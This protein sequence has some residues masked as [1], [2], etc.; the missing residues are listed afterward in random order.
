MAVH[1]LA[2]AGLADLGDEARLII[3]GDEVIEVVV[4]LQNHAAAAPAVAAAGP[5]LGDEGFAMERD[6]AFAAVPRP[7]VNFDFVNEH[8]SNV[9][10]D[11]RRLTLY[12]ILLESR[13]LDSYLQ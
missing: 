1:A 11:V 5:A 4:G 3:L 8:C 13:Y 12:L 7:R 6:T 2:Q 10:A 9:G